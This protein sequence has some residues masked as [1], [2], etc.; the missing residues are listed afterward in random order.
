M[1]I[2][3]SAVH[4]VDP[5]IKTLFRTN[6][7]EG[8]ASYIRLDQNE[9]PDGV[10]LW[11]FKK[12]MKKITPSY[13]SLYPEEICFT[14]KYAHL[15]GLKYENVTL[16][17][18]SVVAMSYA[19]K[20]FGEPGK[21]LLCVTPTFGM[22]KV[23]ADMSQ[24]NTEFI[25]YEPD[26]TFDINKLIEKIDTNTSLVSLVNPSMPIGNVY[27]EQDIERVVQAAASVNALVIIDEAYHY[28][29]EKNSLELIKKY[30]NV[31]ILR[32]F[33]KFLS[34][35]GLRMG[36]V[37]SAEEN[38]RYI[39]NY[40]PHY[41][42]NGA[43]L[44]FGETVIDNFDRLYDDLQ[45]TFLEG[46]HFL[47]KALNT[48]GYS[49]IPTEGC[50]ICIRPKHKSA[51]QITEELKD[52]NILIFCGKGDSAGFLR[53]TIWS[54]KYMKCFINALKEIDR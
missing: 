33:S 3:E 35:P 53:V 4:Y 45:K 48:E 7:P 12:A 11:L 19:I 54:K 22:Y 27:A 14:E 37:I 23:Y 10:P 26:Y 13:L 2:R 6:Q 52:R 44:A 21:K 32:T 42:V 9:N 28:F 49:Y 40:K 38:I 50:F 20:V 30:D 47:L 39:K 41:T 36:A 43:A 8:R 16:T 29:Y 31:V 34:L 17:D 51:E 25:H 18:G 46:K 1:I 5:I 24:M 15:L